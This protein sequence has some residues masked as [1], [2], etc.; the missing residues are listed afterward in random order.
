MQWPASPNGTTRFADGVVVVVVQ[1]M[2]MICPARA[3]P[4]NQQL[5]RLLAGASPSG[6]LI[7]HLIFPIIRLPALL[8]PLLRSPA[9]SAGACAHGS[10]G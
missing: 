4:Q 9:L 8:V 2:E 6:C 1:A 5:Y 10:W 7:D 3:I